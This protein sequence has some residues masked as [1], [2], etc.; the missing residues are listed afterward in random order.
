[1]DPRLTRAAR[2]VYRAYAWVFVAFGVAGILGAHLELE[3]LYG[4]TLLP[5]QRDASMSLL[6]QLRFLRGLEVGFGM[7][8]LAVTDGFF[9][10]GPR[11]SDVNRAVLA[12]LAAVPA[13]RTVSLLVDGPAQPWMTALLV[14]EFAL[15]LWLRN[16]TQPTGSDPSPPS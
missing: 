16:A 1:M 4:L 14:V 7:V 3:A 12:G 6:N 10:R 9:R 2:P 11:R 15:F 8:M 13:A 5:E